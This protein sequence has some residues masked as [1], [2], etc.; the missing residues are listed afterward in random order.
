MT[1]QAAHTSIKQGESLTQTSGL[2]RLGLF[3]LFLICEAAIFIFGSHYFDV[4]PM[5]K[6]LTFNLSV[7][8]LFLA[9]ALWSK[10]DKHWNRY[11]QVAFAF[12][13]A[14]VAYP[15]TAYFD[16]WIS[17]VLGRFAATVDTSKGLAIAKVCEMILK[18]VPILV[19]VKL[20]GADLGSIFLKR[21]NLKG[22]LGVGI[23]VFLNFSTSALLF[24]TTRYTNLVLLGDAIVWGFVFS[25]TNGF[26][27]ELWLRGILLKPLAQHLGV[28]SS[29][30]LTAIVFAVMHGVAYYFMPAVLPVFVLNTLTLGLACGYVMMKTDSI[31]G[32]TLIHA[33]AD[34]FLF[35][36]VLANV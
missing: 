22:G 17:A 5:N 29:V 19:L 1:I 24:F 4:F 21:G 34:F 28:G 13:I 33:A 11:W 36:A 3:I 2:R 14:S 32:A 16:P 6:N 26:M 30:L 23:L 35:V 18:V 15:I 7:S 31:W 20:S 25:F 27:E 12:F 8:A 9:I 10:L